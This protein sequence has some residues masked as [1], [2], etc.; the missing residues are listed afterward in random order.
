M[1]YTS[2]L[3]IIGPV[4]IGP[5]SSHTAGAVRLGVL[6]RKIFNKKPTKINFTLYNSF[7]KTG[8]GHGTDKGVLAGVMGMNVNDTN[9]KNIFELADKQ[10]ISHEFYYKND[11]NRH[12]NSVDINFIREKPLTISGN[13]IGAGGIEIN[14]IN[15]YPVS[16]RG[17]LP[18]L[19][20]IYKDKPGMI[21]KVSSI[22]Q[23][24]E[25]NIATLN[26]NRTDKGEEASM[27]ITLDMILPYEGIKKLKNLEDVYLV[28]NIEKIDR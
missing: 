22:I 27:V 20:L 18:T 11:E 24:Y 8:K 25:V 4:M 1:K 28:R 19:L 14:M 16:L 23:D 10:Q 3:D 7:A 6:A 21:S 26:C 13:S 17:D 2:I 9:I 12:P 15:E 5:S